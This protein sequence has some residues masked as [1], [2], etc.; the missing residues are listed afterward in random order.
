MFTILLS[1]RE[2]TEGLGCRI[3]DFVLP[4]TSSHS[5]TF[6]EH[7][8]DCIRCGHTLTQQH[9]REDL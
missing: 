8:T 1:G 5:F 9:G 7:G 2:Q 4:E 6:G 3:G